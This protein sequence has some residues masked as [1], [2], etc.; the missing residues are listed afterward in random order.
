MRAHGRHLNFSKEADP[1][2]NPKALRGPC[3]FTQ[4]PEPTLTGLEGH[5]QRQHGNPQVKRLHLGRGLHR[6]STCL[7]LSQ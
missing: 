7:S 2:R 3:F 6:D 4:G 5:Q 1:E